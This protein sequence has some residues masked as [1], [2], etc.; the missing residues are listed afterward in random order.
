M[1][2]KVGVIGG[3]GYKPLYALSK[4]ASGGGVASTIDNDLVGS[5]IT[6]GVVLEYCPGGD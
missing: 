6:I 5:D 3:N 1:V 2:L 4:W